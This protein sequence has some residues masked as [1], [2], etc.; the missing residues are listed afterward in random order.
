MGADRMTT[1]CELYKTD[2]EAILQLRSGLVPGPKRDIFLTDLVKWIVSKKFSKV[3][4]LTSTEADERLDNQIRGSQFRFISKHFEND[5]KA[6]EFLELE[7]RQEEDIFIPGSGFTKALYKKC[8][9]ED[10]P[11]AIFMSFASEGNNSDD[12]ISLAKYLN[13]WVQIIPGKFKIP[14][15]WESFYGGPPPTIIYN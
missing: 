15:S 12:G 10:I 2:K 6:L 4:L 9:D 7:K 1:A 14:P 11:T 3:I 5:L 8:L 13:S